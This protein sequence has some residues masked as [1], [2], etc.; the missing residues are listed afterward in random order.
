MR[1]HED[2]QRISTITRTF[3]NN[4]RHNK[5]RVDQDVDWGENSR[6]VERHPQLW[7]ASQRPQSEI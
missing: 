7:T 1:I 5:P 3:H 6:K 2:G 4:T